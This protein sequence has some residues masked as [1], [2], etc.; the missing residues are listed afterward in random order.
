MPGINGRALAQQMRP[1]NPDMRVLYVSGFADQTVEQDAVDPN[2]AFLAKP[3]LLR[4]LAAK[5]R[6]LFREPK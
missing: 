3:F 2:N 1:L 4:E 6:E 5:L